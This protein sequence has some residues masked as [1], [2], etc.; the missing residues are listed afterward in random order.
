MK[1][2]YDARSGYLHSGEPMYISLLYRGHEKYDIDPSLGM[3]IDRCSISD[4]K[5]LPTIIFWEGLVRNCILNYLYDKNKYN[6]QMKNI[7]SG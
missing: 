4:S 7:Q 3:I 5:K 2:I 6:S 1:H